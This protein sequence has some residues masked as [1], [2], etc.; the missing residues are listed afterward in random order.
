ME[1]GFRLRK[2]PV[3]EPEGRVAGSAGAGI[4]PGVAAVS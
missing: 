2:G 3:E 1:R 4:C